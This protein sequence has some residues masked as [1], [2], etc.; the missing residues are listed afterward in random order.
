MAISHTSWGAVALGATLALSGCSGAIGDR[1]REGIEGEDEVPALRPFDPAPAYVYTAKVKNLL[2][3]LPPTAQE[4]DAVAADPRA[5]EGLVDAWFRDPAAEKKIFKFFGNAFQQTQFIK[6]D[7]SDQGEIRGDGKFADPVVTALRESFGRTVVAMVKEGRPFTEVLTSNRHQMTPAMMVY[8]AYLDNRRVDDNGRGRDKLYE[9]DKTVTFT[10]HA[11][12]GTQTV[13]PSPSHPHW[14]ITTPFKNCAKTERTFSGPNVHNALMELIFGLVNDDLADTTCKLFGTPP[15]LVPEDFTTWKWVTV[16]RPKPGEATS[17]FYDLAAIRNGS[18]LVL[19]IPRVGFFTTPAFFA[20][21]RTNTSNVARVTVNQALIVA[22]G[23]SFDA[24]NTVVPVSESG[25]DEEH[26][27]P[28]TD[29]YACHRTL[30][31]M[32]QFFRKNL[33][34]NYHEQSDPKELAQT[35]TFAMDGISAPGSTLEDLARLLADHPRFA[36]AWTQKLCF[37]ANSAPCSEDDAEF[38]RVAKEFRESG[39]DFR[40]LVRELFASPLVTAAK[41]VKTF[42]DRDVVVS[43]SRYDHLCASL[44]GR[45]GFD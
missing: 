33:S 26:A 31:P 13:P 12:D 45:L 44:S 27:N 6:D 42:N 37:Y 21:W 14:Y 34:L 8:L 15:Q 16:R 3:G 25:L 1:D 41:R 20:N 24:A 36:A 4:L 43:I 7:L 28:T 32:R 30:D 2:T 40:T 23:R 22:L 38:E 9:A 18:E 35:A 17:R 39:H 29:C 11:G 19:D 5:L 10:V